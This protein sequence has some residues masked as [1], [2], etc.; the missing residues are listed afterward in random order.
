MHGIRQWFWNL[1]L[2]RKLNLVF[3]VTCSV[4]LLVA[5]AALFIFQDYHFRR[6]MHRDLR[7]TAEII[8]ANSVGSL[9]FKD[10][11]GAAEVLAALKAKPHITWARIELSDGTE[12]A[13][14]G[15][16]HPVGWRF[17]AVTRDGLRVEGFRMLLAQPIA[18]AGQRLGT[19]YLFADTGATHATL[20]GLYA[21]LCAV[22]LGVSLLLGL[23][24][25][26]RLQGIISDPIL[27]LAKTAHVVAQEKNYHVRAR[28]VG[29]DEVGLLTDAFNQMLSQIE[30]DAAALRDMNLD[31]QCEIEERERVELAR[32][33]SDERFRSLTDSASDA[34]ITIDS[35]G[36]TISWNKGARE[37]FGYH[38]G[39][40]VGEAIAALLPG[41]H[42]LG[43]EEMMETLRAADEFGPA[44]RVIELE[45]LSQGGSEVP[46]ELSLY[47]WRTGPE[48]Y[49]G[50]IVRN[51][52]ERRR[53]AQ[54]LEELNRRLLETSRQAGM[55]EIATSVLHN[56][57][58]VLNS[59]NIS[60][61]VLEDTIRG[62]KVGS[63]H[64][65]ATL[66]QDNAGRLGE[67]FQS[68]PRG[69]KVPAFLNQLAN[70]LGGEQ[71]TQLEELGALRKYI[72]HI[73]EI[74]AMQ[75]SYARVSGVTE[76]LTPASLVED[77]LR[78]DSGQLELS[79]VEVVREFETVAQTMVDRHKVMQI[80]V[81][82]IRNARH[83]ICEARTEGRRMRV[84]LYRAAPDQMAIA[85][86]DN[87]VGIAP[88]NVLRVFQH[89]YTTKRDGHGF[90]LHSGANAAK[91]LGGSLTAQSEGPGQ[92]ATF[93]LVLPWKSVENPAHAGS[94]TAFTARN[95]AASSPAASPAGTPTTPTTPTTHPTSPPAAAA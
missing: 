35:Q 28:K 47:A 52:T 69:Q 72:E 33:G 7:A 73:K 83:A 37:I 63:V 34:I 62:G 22:V 10:Q 15:G 24:L 64:K 18:G 86:V 82:L 75:Q 4:V 74:V 85:I 26:R 58:N 94:A 76:V 31:L 30:A 45:G 90:G 78:I 29:A 8:A 6:E 91:E 3:G 59:V 61:S 57:G 89:G 48:I 42:R 36:R 1:G 11:Q 43:L 20:M 79:R 77:A 13:R 88:E 12:F 46:I 17:E 70:Q 40:I 67:F 80:L 56:V 2:Q 9:T 60:A 87:G 39:D 23:R 95:A 16:T 68:D 66:L 5:C 71:K 19:L 54:E 41:R 84:R 92:G 38:E 44:S 55:A 53:A 50:A 25:S 32:R 49:F 93:T 51:I 21:V 65:L 27:Q 81:N 14:V